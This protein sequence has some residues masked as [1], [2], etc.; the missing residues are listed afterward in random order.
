M[1][2]VPGELDGTYEGEGIGDMGWYGRP[3][4]G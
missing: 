4:Y 2:I 1:V 3:P